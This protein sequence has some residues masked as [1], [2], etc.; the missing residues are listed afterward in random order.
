LVPSPN[1]EHWRDDVDDGVV[2]GMAHFLG[3]R[4]RRR[5]LE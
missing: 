5:S 1:V 3:K 4:K 2:V